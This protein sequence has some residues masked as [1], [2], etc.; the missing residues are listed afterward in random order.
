MEYDYEYE[1]NMAEAKAGMWR[2]T[3]E[4]DFELMEPYKTQLTE[5]R[6]TAT[7]AWTTALIEYLV[8]HSP[9]DAETLKNELLRRCNEEGLTAM[10]IVEEFV[11]ESLGGDL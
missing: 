7:A 3:D 8:E 11:L 2:L 10:E 5:A 6:L 4:G 9:Y 1:G